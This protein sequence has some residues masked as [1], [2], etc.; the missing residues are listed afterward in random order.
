MS[1]LSAIAA[2]PRR[3]ISAL[4]VV[5]AAV[6]ITVGSGADFTAHAANP[7]NTFST[8]TLSIGNSASSAVLSTPNLKPGDTGS[9]T[10]DIANSGSV[11][12]TF[13]LS[14]SNLV[15]AGTPKLLPQL[16]LKIEDCGLFS[17]TNPP[18]CTTGT[19]VVYT[20]KASGVTPIT[21]GTYA[22]SAK[23]R[24]QFSVTLPQATDNSFQGKTASLEFDW[25]ATS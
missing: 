20:G 7:A 16:D 5:L 3:T 25:D 9:G 4:A 24:Y 19:T 1:R 17:G 22:G 10:V 8:G 23:H 12:G 18:S 11:S 13:T 2:H 6:G 15:D 21:L 14:T